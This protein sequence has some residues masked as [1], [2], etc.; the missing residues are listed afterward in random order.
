MNINQ[1]FE[2]LKKSGGARAA[3]MVLARQLSISNEQLAIKSDKR[4]SLF[5]IIG[6]KIAARQLRRGVPVAKIIGRKWFFGMEFETNGHTL[7]PR[8]DSEVDFKLLV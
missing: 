7:D 2:I 6:I 3:R 8:P 5:Q 1:A 4:L